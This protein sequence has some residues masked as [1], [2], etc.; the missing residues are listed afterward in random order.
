MIPHLSEAKGSYLN[1]QHFK[2]AFQFPVSF[3]TLLNSTNS[4]TDRGVILSAEH[5]TDF[6]QSQATVLLG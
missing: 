1:I 6:A 4:L 3:G 2:R 5:R